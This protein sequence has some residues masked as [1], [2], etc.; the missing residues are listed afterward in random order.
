M[1]KTLAITA[2]L[3]GVSTLVA[4]AQS[5]FAGKYDV[6]NGY[7]HGSAA[8]YAGYGTATV[9][10]NGKVAFSLYY[11]SLGASSKGSGSINNKGLFR[12]SEGTRGSGQMVGKKVAVGKFSNSQ[13][14]GF[15]CLN[16][17]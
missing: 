17:K 1:Q 10:K 7:T 13:G 9:A 14:D 5:Q 16:K 12:L 8:G 15:F 6:F 4:N 2:C 3:L 11:P